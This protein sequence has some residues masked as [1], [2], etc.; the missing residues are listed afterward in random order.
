MTVSAHDEAAAASPL[1]NRLRRIRDDRDYYA[2]TIQLGRR[3]NIVW[4]AQTM[5]VGFSSRQPGWELRQASKVD[6]H[7]MA[8][9]WDQVLHQ[10]WIAVHN[11]LELAIF[12]RLGGNALVDMRVANTWL[13]EVVGVREC[14][15]DT[16]GFSTTQHLPNTAL[17]RAPSR[18]LR[19]QVLRRDGFR[20]VICGRRP[21]DYVDVELH[22]HH[23]LPWGRHG[24]TAE[25]NLV[26]LCGTCH[27]GLDPHTEPK[28][29][30]LA[31]LPGPA[32]V[33]TA[34]DAAEF[35]ASVYAYRQKVASLLDDADGSG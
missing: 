23:V 24:P 18:K 16:A 17:R 20:C 14:V 32:E 2:L 15:H 9:A 27:E 4:G 1:L 29:R 6:P 25:E 11:P 19:M 31:S 8:K 13:P 21:A 3:G 12:L 5:W 10:G 28:L 26:T 7:W 34:P 35:A 22:V 30:E 33:E